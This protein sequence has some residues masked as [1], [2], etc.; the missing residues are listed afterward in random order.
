MPIS[1][2]QPDARYIEQTRCQEMTAA[3]GWRCLS[4]A[5]ALGRLHRAGVENPRSHER[6]EKVQPDE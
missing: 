3:N 5:Q 4:Y 6:L 2:P 1:R